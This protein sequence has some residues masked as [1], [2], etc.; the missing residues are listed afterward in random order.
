MDVGRVGGEAARPLPGFAHVGH[1]ADV[2]GAEDDGIAVS[3]HGDRKAGGIGAEALYV[4]GAT[5]RMAAAGPPVHGAAV[6]VRFLD[7][8]CDTRSGQR[9]S[10]EA[11]PPCGP[12]LG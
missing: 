3:R 7:I 2:Q 8:P 5:E 10:R 12:T 1:L 6:L 9:P 4:G 11:W